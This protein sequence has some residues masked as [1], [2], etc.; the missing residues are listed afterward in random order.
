MAFGPGR[1]YDPVNLNSLKRSLESE[2]L[3]NSVVLDLE[4]PTVDR[5]WERSRMCG[6]DQGKIPALPYLP[7]ADPSGTFARAA[8]PVL[9]GLGQ[10]LAG[11]Q[12]SAVLLDHSGLFLTHYCDDGPLRQ[13]MEAG[14]SAP[15]FVWAEEFAGTSA[16]GIALEERVPAWTTGSDHYLEMLR[17]LTCVAAPVFNPFTHKFEGVIDLTALKSNSSPLMLPIVMQA[18]RAVEE[19]MLEIGSATERNLLARFMAAKRRPGNVVMVRGERTDVSTTNAGI[20]L[21]T[22][23]KTLLFQRADDMASRDAVSDHITLS[24]GRTA[25]VRFESI[26]NAGHRI[27]SMVEVALEAVPAKSGADARSARDTTGSDS[28]MAG[29]SQATRFLRAKVDQL[30]NSTFPLVISGDTGVGKLTLARMLATDG[31][32]LLDAG[33]ASVDTEPAMLREVAGVV[34]MPDRSVIIRDIGALSVAGLQ[35]LGVLAESAEQNGSRLICTFTERENAESGA[36][37]PAFGVRVHVPALRERPEDL[38]DLVPRLLTRRGFD[39][40]LSAPVM[41]ILMRY[42]WPGNV[43]ELDSVLTAMAKGCRGREITLADVPFHYQRG[44]RRLRRIEHVERTAIIQA[45]QESEG[46][47][48]KAAELLEIGRATLYRKMRVYGLESEMLSN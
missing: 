45:L 7:D 21:S 17:D 11:T 24:S 46:N 5:S 30:A 10:M 28:P 19:R 42:D 31:V 38:L 3:M 15:G 20:L 48:T 41:Q 39:I 1:G 33:R 25:T 14:Q 6:L 29:R 47:K 23:D 26:T 34:A 35:R 44:A 18:A 22:S 8:A 12:T 16:V 9:E 37:S 13:R 32:V 4:R 2:T 27:G 43:R 40:R 36:P